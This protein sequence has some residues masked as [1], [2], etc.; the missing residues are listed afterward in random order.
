MQL[1]N[2]Y[3]KA[4]HVTPSPASQVFEIELPAMTPLPAPAK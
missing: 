3:C 2:V 1:L 4:A